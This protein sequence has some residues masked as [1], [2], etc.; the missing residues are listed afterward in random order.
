MTTFFIALLLGTYNLLIN[1][2]HKYKARTKVCKSSLKQLWQW[3]LIMT[4][5]ICSVSV[6]SL[7]QPE[8]PI[9][10]KQDVVK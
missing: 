5:N 3:T 8:L 9:M 2:G 1:C 4:F 10:Q 6:L 7:T